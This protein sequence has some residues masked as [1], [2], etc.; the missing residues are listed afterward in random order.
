MNV[1]HPSFLPLADDE[2]LSR[3]PAV[4]DP[5][6]CAVPQQTRVA[7]PG[8]LP[9]VVVGVHIERHSAKPSVSDGV[10]EAAAAG[11]SGGIR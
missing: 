1:K 3:I 4:T 9:R 7:V 6:P 11:A 8:D 2:E 10:D 5:P